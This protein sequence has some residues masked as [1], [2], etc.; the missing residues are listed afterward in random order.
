[1]L[2]KGTDHGVYNTGSPTLSNG[3]ICT[4]Q[5]DQNGNL[6]ISVATGSVG[7]ISLNGLVGALALTSTG[8]SIVITPSG[9]TI[10]LETANASLTN[11]H[12]FVGNAS[13]IAT[14]VAMSGDATISNTGA[15]TLATVNSDTGSFGSATQVAV[16]TVNGK[17]LITA[18]SNVTIAGTTPGGSAGGDL[19]GTYPN[20]TI[21]NDV[22]LSG[23]PT[24]TTQSSAD[25][26]TKIAT[27][28]YVTSAVNTILAMEPNKAACKYSTIA[29]LPA[30]I[31]NNGSSGVGATLTGVSVGALSID[32]ATPSVGESVLVKNEVT[33]ANNGIYTVTTVGSGIAVYVLT[34]RTDFNTSTE[35]T[36]GDVTFVTNGSVLSNT[37]WQMITAGTIIVGTTAIV[38]TQIAGVGTY[39]AGTGLTLTASTFSISVSYAGQT[40][41]T[42]LGAISAGSWNAPGSIRVNGATT[43]GIDCLANANNA[44]IGA[45][46]TSNTSGH[47]ARLYAEVAGNN[48]GSDPFT[49]YKNSDA[50]NSFDW[51]VGGDTSDSGAFIISNNATLG[52]NNRFRMTKA[53]AITTALWNAT[54]ISEIY[55]GTNQTTYATGDILYSSAANTLSKLTGNITTTKK[56]LNQTGSGS[57]SAAPAWSALTVA[58]LPVGAALQIIQ[59]A[60]TSVFS[61][62]SSTKTDW[63][64]MSATIVTT[65]ASSKISVSLTSGVSSDNVNAFQYV[66]LFFNVNGGSYTQIALGD[67]ASSAQRCWVDAATVGNS[68]YNVQQKPLAGIFLHTHGQAAGATLIYKLQVAI[69]N[70]SGTSYWGRTAD[71]ADGNRSSI[72]ST[73]TL[74]EY[75]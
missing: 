30:N 50:T 19:T 60:K 62:T 42:T 71:L 64:G 41:I 51:A 4:L 38:W 32:G 44:N 31:Y 37:T 26:S 34:R 1:M 15:V 13:N 24:T 21:K 28:A 72:P 12:I 35:I 56:F 7:V 36:A 2:S 68:S 3:E 45:T 59:T 10:N 43:V 46:L 67:T 33:Q 20:P 8:N 69:T 14:D 40:S 61:T 57:A 18:I 23:N 54:A 75:A 11:T 70:A 5:V 16:T 17:G 25:N 9:N 22:A 58:D 73:L 39:L 52:T 63:T 6:R 55:G 29:A 27:T 47:H 53:G 65:T 74:T 66:Y 48:S 49:N